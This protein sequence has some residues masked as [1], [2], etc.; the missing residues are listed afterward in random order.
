MFKEFQE[1]Q[2]RSC[3]VILFNFPENKNDCGDVQHLVS[4]V[5]NVAVQVKNVARIGKP[6]KNGY[7]TL[8]VSLQNSEEALSVIRKC[9]SL[10]GRDVFVSPDL[11]AM[12]R[13]VESRVRDEFR[14]RTKD[15]ETNLRIKYP[16]SS[17]KLDTQ[18]Q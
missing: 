15:G 13:G 16:F 17:Y 4:T 12:Q 2:N 5:M 10:K 1:R 18:F 7:R 3:D 6:D 9:I 14:Q 8:K 11:T